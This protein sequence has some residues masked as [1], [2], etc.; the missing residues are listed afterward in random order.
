MKSASSS[1][2]QA[3][4]PKKNGSFLDEIRNKK[5]RPTENLNQSGS[6]DKQL[7]KSSTS[8]DLFSNLHSTLK[9]NRIFLEIDDDSNNDEEFVDSD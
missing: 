9:Q 3:D 1:T 5:L 6:E 7:P 2:S 4:T 8:G